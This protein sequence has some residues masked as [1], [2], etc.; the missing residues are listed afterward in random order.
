MQN[1]NDELSDLLVG[2]Y[3]PPVVPLT[4]DDWDMLNAEV[5]VE[6][7]NNRND[8][9]YDN[10]YSH[11]N[12]DDTDYKFRYNDPDDRNQNDSPYI[13]Q[14]DA[15]NYHNRYDNSNDPMENDDNNRNIFDNSDHKRNI[16]DNSD[17]NDHY[18]NQSNNDN[19]DDDDDDRYYGVSRLA[20]AN[21][22]AVDFNRDGNDDRINCWISNYKE[23]VSQS[24]KIDGK[25]M[26]TN[27]MFCHNRLLC[28][29]RVQCQ[30]SLQTVELQC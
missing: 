24:R 28:D 13:N 16:Y 19:D 22:L 15:T 23:H 30:K 25:L 12:D 10:I 11:H 14:Y 4:E 21:P 27:E 20:E 17:H 7:Q 8:I 1:N 2:V 18:D 6:S 29:S 26:E 3:Y 9:N 5:Q